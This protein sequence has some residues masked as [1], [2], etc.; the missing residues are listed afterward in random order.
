MCER[1][2]IV[3]VGGSLLNEVAVRSRGPEM[4][5]GEDMA[6]WPMGLGSGQAEGPGHPTVAPEAHSLP[7][8]PGLGRHQKLTFPPMT[9]QTLTLE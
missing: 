7:P 4:P 3:N 9:S 1:V 6:K 5:N 8:P 2:D